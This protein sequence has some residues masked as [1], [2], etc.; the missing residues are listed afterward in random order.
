MTDFKMEVFHEQ[1]V[2]RAQFF[3]TSSTI[4]ENFMRSVSFLF[5]IAI[6]NS[7]KT[8]KVIAYPK[9]GS[10]ITDMCITA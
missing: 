4:N 9:P 1:I 7:E 5:V 2:A 3:V 6:L 8:A 10:V